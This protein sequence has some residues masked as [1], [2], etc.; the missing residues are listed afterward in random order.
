MMFTLVQPLIVPPLLANGHRSNHKMKPVTVQVF[1]RDEA[2]AVL[3][4]V[5]YDQIVSCA[6]FSQQTRSLIVKKTRSLLKRKGAIMMLMHFTRSVLGFTLR[7]L[8]ISGAQTI[9]NWTGTSY[10][11]KTPPTSCA[12]Q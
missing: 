10:A 8:S 2:V 6:H 11:G 12:I 5:C 9:A 7:S 3:D 1:N 4:K